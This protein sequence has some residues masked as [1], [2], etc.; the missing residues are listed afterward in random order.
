MTIINWP[1]DTKEIIEKMRA[2]NY[3]WNDIALHFGCNVLTIRN[4]AIKLNAHV[5]REQKRFTPEEDAELRRA[6]IDLEDLKV[7]AAKM[8][9]SYGVIR[10]RLYHYHHDLMFTTR[11]SESQRAVN[12]YGKEVLSAFDENYERAA[13]KIKAA[14]I[15]AKSIARAQAIAAREQKLRSDFEIADKE[16]AQGK[17][18]NEAIFELRAS[19]INL[20]VIGNHFNITRERIRQIFDKVATNK[21]Y[22]IAIQKEAPHDK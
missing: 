18:R 22:A 17:N 12:R 15:E 8:G 4:K 3:S 7:T 13:K 1:A 19:G 14:K 21:A 10:Q 5:A 11:T 16:I 2:N 20:E 6:Y 9:R